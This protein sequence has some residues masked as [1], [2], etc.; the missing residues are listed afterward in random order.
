MNHWPFV[1]ASYVI[2]LISTAAVIANS[3]AAMRKAEGKAE[4]LGKRK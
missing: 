2:V 3:F 4:Q 1:I